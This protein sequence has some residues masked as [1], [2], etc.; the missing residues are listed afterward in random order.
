MPV[1]DYICQ[2]CQKTFE[3]ALTLD[4]HDHENAKCPDCGSRNVEQEASAFYAVTSK[5]S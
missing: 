1:Y 4:E 5:K 3:V 2:D